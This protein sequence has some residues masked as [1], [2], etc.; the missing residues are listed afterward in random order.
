MAL[1]PKTTENPVV[2]S[3]FCHSLGTGRETDIW[4]RER[5]GAWGDNTSFCLLTLAP[6]GGSNAVVVKSGG[7]VG[8]R[9]RRRRFQSLFGGRPL[10]LPLPLPSTHSTRKRQSGQL[11]SKAF[12]LSRLPLSLPSALFTVHCSLCAPPKI[13][14]CELGLLRPSRCEIPRPKMSRYRSVL[15]PIAILR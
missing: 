15:R 13:G 12:S 8:H 5:E 1:P 7:G 3:S 14:L 10:P 4:R 6:R 2:A 9:R 11:S